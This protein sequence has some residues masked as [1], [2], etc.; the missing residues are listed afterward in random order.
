MQL[1]K[2]W[3]YDYALSMVKPPLG[4]ILRFL[5]LFKLKLNSFGQSQLTADTLSIV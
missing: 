1:K 2:Q 5:M 3:D 4:H